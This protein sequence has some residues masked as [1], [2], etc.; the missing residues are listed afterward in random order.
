MKK[1]TLTVLSLL[2]LFAT[3]AAQPN[4]EPVTSEDLV[5][6]VAPQTII[7]GRNANEGNVW[8]T[9]HAEIGYSSVT[10]LSAKIDDIEGA[11]EEQLTFPD[12]RGELVVKFWY[13]DVAALLGDLEDVEATVTLTVTYEEDGQT[14]AVTGSD[15]IR[16]LDKR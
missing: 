12:N 5:I 13:D 15:V 1:L 6:Q 3:V 7:L 14:F 2:L 4:P 9:I 10:G 11:I 8:V 16:I